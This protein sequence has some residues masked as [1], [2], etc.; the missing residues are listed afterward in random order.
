VKFKNF[1]LAGL[2]LFGLIL[3]YSISNSET[4]I[5][6]KENTHSITEY[7]NMMDYQSSQ[8][9]F[10]LTASDS[11]EKPQVNMDVYRFKEKSI[12]R[13]FL[14]S[15]LIPG[16]GEFYAGSKIKAAIFFGMEAAFWTGYFSYHKK[17]KDKEN[18]FKDF[19]DV[20]WSETAYKDWLKYHYDVPLDTSTGE[21]ILIPGKYV[22]LSDEDDS[23]EIR[24]VLPSSKTQQYYEMI[25]K[26][27]HFRF[28]WDDF[29]SAQSNSI[30]NRTFYLDLRYDS[31]NLLDK[32]NRFVMI[33]L[34]NHLLSAFDAA[35]SV[36]SYNRK[37]DRFSTIDI[38][39]RLAEYNRE[40]II[41]KLTLS[42]KF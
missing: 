22:N 21:V 39:L 17:G 37:G 35:I 20:H 9:L 24:E 32:A 29:D 40:E 42:T 12:K 27:D 1:K 33:S 2:V 18:E 34:A 6:K 14:Y 36:R 30:F 41:P 13:G 11:T 15:L 38:N 19:A 3:L 28:G 16:A 25:G 8:K 23:I 31:N 26:Y 5:I 7:M 10:A 4:L